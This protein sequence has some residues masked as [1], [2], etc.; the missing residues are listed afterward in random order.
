MDHQLRAGIESQF[1]KARLEIQSLA[2]GLQVVNNLSTY[3]QVEADVASMLTISVEIGFYAEDLPI[4]DDTV[5]LPGN[6]SAPFPADGG[7]G[8]PTYSKPL[9]ANDEAGQIET[10]F[11]ATASPQQK[12]IKRAS[13]AGGTY[14]ELERTAFENGV[15]ANS[16]RETAANPD[17]TPPTGPTE[18]ID[19]DAWAIIDGKLYLSYDKGFAEEFASRPEEYLVKAEANWP[20]LKARLEQGTAD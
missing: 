15:D 19:P 17:A 18:N 8:C 14:D 3:S 7:E 10:V 1:C 13:E 2:R 11:Q 9:L 4:G 12:Q 20:E 5:A 16:M 6:C